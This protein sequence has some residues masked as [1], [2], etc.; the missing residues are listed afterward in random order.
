[1]KRR[2]LLIAPPALAALTFAVGA[3]AQ[4]GGAPVR[5]LVG[6]PAGGSTDTLARS[7]AV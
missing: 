3:R 6:A 2:D 4:I 5:I 1:M 7:L